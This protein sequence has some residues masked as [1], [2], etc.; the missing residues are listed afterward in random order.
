M[1]KFALLLEVHF[2]L[3]SEHHQLSPDTLLSPGHYPAAREM[4]VAQL[5]KSLCTP[6][7]PSPATSPTSGL[8]QE[9]AKPVSRWVLA[10]KKTSTYPFWR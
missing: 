10:I 3:F 2:L 8:Y 4:R 5:F 6:T 7:I 9:E 1:V